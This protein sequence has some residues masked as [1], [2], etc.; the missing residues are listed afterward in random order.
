MTGVIFVT[1]TRSCGHDF[2]WLGGS[3]GPWGN[4]GSKSVDGR[5][6]SVSPT[7]SVKNAFQIK[8]Y[9]Y[10]NHKENTYTHIHKYRWTQSPMLFLNLLAYLFVF[11]SY[12]ESK[13]DLPTVDFLKYPSCP[14]LGQIQ[15]GLPE[16]GT[17][18]CSLSQVGGMGTVH[19]VDTC[20][21][22]GAFVGSRARLQSKERN[23]RNGCHTL[24][25]TTRENAHSSLSSLYVLY[26]LIRTSPV[27]FFF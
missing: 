23:K 25:L 9:K 6:L 27:F 14:S 24:S 4:L 26:L 17:K 13:R 22:P 11:E 3:H 7:L 21:L 8:L 20:C 1:P 15:P 10:L 5:S 16:Q 2:S 18:H 12:E 19:G